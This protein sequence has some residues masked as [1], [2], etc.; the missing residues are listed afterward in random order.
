MAI[1]DR[2]WQSISMVFIV[3]LQRA[4]RQHNASFVVV[5]RLTKMAH[6]IP[7]TKKVCATHVGDLF[8]QHVFCIH[9][10]PETIVSD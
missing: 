1:Q 10:L 3:G 2:K 5:D 7:T 4:Q 9:G 6:S 8:I